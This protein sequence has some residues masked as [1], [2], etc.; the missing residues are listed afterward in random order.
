MTEIKDDDVRAII[1]RL[2][3]YQNIKN[4]SSIDL[5]KI[6]LYATQLGVNYNSW[7]E[8]K[9]LNEILR[10]DTNSLCKSLQ[11]CHPGLDIVSIKCVTLAVYLHMYIEIQS[12]LFCDN[13]SDGCSE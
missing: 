11:Y 2:I 5:Y 4:N 3:K 12:I 8:N 6:M 13:I 1:D 10:E 7:K 9:E